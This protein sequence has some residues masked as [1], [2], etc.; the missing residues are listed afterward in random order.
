M[1]ATAVAA[2][3]CGRK[4]SIYGRSSTEC[5]ISRDADAAWKTS[6]WFCLST[7]DSNQ[8][9]RIILSKTRK[10]GAR[11]GFREF[12]FMRLFSG[13]LF[14]D[15][16]FGT[17]LFGRLRTAARTLGE[18]R[19]DL[20]DRLGLGDALNRRDLARQP[21]KSSFVKLPFRV[22]LLGLVLTGKGRAQPR[23]WRRYRRN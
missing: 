17:A 19:F 12:R 5:A 21:I 13:R 1:R 15:A 4:Q 20:L 3:P 16:F 2:H 8:P 10:P 23:Q 14:L 6:E 22:R 18:S 11:P 9:P 7:T